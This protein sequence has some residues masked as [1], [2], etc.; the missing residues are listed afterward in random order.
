MNFRSHLYQTMFRQGHLLPRDSGSQQ[1]LQNQTETGFHVDV[2]D[3]TTE[4]DCV[5]LFT[6]GAVPAV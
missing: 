5:T 6:Q 3:E 1:D 4:I 2:A